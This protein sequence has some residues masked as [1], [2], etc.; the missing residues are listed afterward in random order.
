MGR[1]FGST[2]EYRYT[3]LAIG[4]S[5]APNDHS[6]QVYEPTRDEWFNFNRNLVQNQ[7]DFVAFPIPLP[8]A[9]CQTYNFPPY[10]LPSLVNE[11]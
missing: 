6:T 4:G 5:G 9:K 7:K 8:F 10:Y 11:T 2:I 1:N 3:F